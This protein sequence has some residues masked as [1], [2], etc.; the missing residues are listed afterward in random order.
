MGELIELLVN[1]FFFSDFG[2]CSTTSILSTVIADPMLCLA[3]I[4]SAK[5]SSSS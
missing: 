5:D 1:N 3:K 2:F 4:L